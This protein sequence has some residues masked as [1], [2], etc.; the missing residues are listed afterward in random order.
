[1]LYPIPAPTATH[2]THPDIGID[3]R[4]NGNGEL[5]IVFSTLWVGDGGSPEYQADVQKLLEQLRPDD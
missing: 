1:V 5:E 4:R 2:D 3:Q